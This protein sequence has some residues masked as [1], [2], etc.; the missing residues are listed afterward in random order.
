MVDPISERA[1]SGLLDLDPPAL[2][3]RMPDLASWR[4]VRVAEEASDLKKALAVSEPSGS[5]YLPENRATSF[6]FCF[7]YLV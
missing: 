6:C 1:L 4:V 5:S 3:L 2:D 7:S